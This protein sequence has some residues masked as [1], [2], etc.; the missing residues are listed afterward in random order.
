VAWTIDLRGDETV[1]LAE[2]ADFRAKRVLEVGAG[3]G[4]LTRRIGAE[5]A[6]LLAIEPD[7][8]RVEQ[9]RAE[10]PH[11]LSG[12]VEFRVMDAVEL[13]VPRRSFDVALL[14]WSL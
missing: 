4:R 5:T 11:E 7:R 3:D 1:A 8:D 13:D 10:L 6:S 12:R 2:V 9:A 14:S